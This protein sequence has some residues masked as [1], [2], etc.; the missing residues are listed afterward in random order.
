MNPR[1]FSPWPSAGGLRPAN[2]VVRR[3]FRLRFPR[4]CG[5]KDAD[6]QPEN[7][8]MR[9]AFTAT[10]LALAAPVALASPQDAWWE[11]L[12]SLC[13]KSFAGEQR[14][15]PPGDTTFQGKAL[16]MHVRSCEPDRIRIPF[17]V[18]DNLSRTWVLTRADGRIT[19]EHDHRH[20]DGSPEDV[21]LYGGITP[22]HGSATAQIFPAHDATVA[23]LPNGYPN[24]WMMSFTP[25][26][27]FTYFVQRLATERAFHVVF[28][29]THEVDAPPAPW[30]W[31]D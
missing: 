30:G 16:V 7:L 22:N 27:G 2:A 5:N 12:Q 24:V 19:L 28:D 25:G 1:F 26:P 31:E 8:P 9:I 21:T 3:A 23:V 14:Y 11:T 13:G 17:V 20:A 10:L 4:R 15:A 6:L 29:L 18:G